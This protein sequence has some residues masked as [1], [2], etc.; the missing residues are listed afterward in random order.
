MQSNEGV[1]NQSDDA[2]GSGDRVLFTRPV[3]LGTEY[4]MVTRPVALGTEYCMVTRPVA[5]GTEY[6][7]VTR[8]VALGTEDCMVTRPVALGTE[9]CSRAQTTMPQ[10]DSFSDLAGASLSTSTECDTLPPLLT[11]W[12]PST[13]TECD[14]LAPVLNVIPLHLY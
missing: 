11:M 8:P 4:C 14:T 10:G 1:S 13:C 12:Y 2:C 9:Y 7:M 6:C 5:L 3:A